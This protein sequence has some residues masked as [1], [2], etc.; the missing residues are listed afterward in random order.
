MTVVILD[1]QGP[2]NVMGF[3]KYVFPPGTINVEL[4]P[5]ALHA[6]CHAFTNAYFHH[7]FKKTAKLMVNKNFI[8]Q[9]NILN[10]SEN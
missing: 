10:I 1:L 8:T 7:I 6:A 9:K 2:A 3:N 4:A 5:P